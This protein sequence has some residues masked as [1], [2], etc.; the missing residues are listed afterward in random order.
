[1]LPC[2]AHEAGERLSPGEM[3]ADTF[4]D[5]LH[6]L[7][8]KQATAKKKYAPLQPPIPASAEFTPTVQVH[9]GLHAVLSSILR[10]QSCEGGGLLKPNPEQCAFLRHF[11][12]RLQLEAGEQRAGKI[13]T[14]RAEPLLDCVHGLPGTGFSK[15]ESSARGMQ[16]K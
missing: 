2:S 8:V 6:A 10:G 11:T 3:F 14:S 12:A 5:H 7:T 13:N 16:C 15:Y 1:M 9:Q 4:D